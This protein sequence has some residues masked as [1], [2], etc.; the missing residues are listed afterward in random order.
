MSGLFWTVSW[1]AR[2]L[3]SMR[4]DFKRTWVEAK[5]GCECGCG[6]IE[7]VLPRHDLPRSDAS[8]P[9]EAEG[10]VFDSAGNECGGLL[11]F[12]RDGCLLSL[13]IYSFDAP[14]PLP[15]LESVRWSGSPA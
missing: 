11:L 8:S 2:F 13:E 10:R 9:V 15:A 1:P 5:R 14:L 7:F 12:V 6:T 4:C 3:V